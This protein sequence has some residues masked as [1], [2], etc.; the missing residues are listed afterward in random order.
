MTDDKKEKSQKPEPITSLKVG[1]YT[2]KDLGTT[3]VAEL[4]NKE[5]APTK[6]KK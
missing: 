5:S 4:E 3:A 2:F 6:R 1:E